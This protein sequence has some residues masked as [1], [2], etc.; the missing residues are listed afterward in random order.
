MISFVHDDG[1]QCSGLE[2][3]LPLTLLKE[4]ESNIDLGQHLGCQLSQQKLCLGRQN[5]MHTSLAEITPS[6]TVQKDR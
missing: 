2:T 5:W 6:T 1:L 4:T 3:R